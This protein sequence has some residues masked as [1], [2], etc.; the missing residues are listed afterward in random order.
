MADKYEDLHEQL[1]GDETFDL[2]EEEALGAKIAFQWLDGHRDQT[3]GRT[4]T[5][6]E[7]GRWSHLINGRYIETPSIIDFLEALGITVVPDSK[8]TNAD[9][10]E[11][12][13][14]DYALQHG[15]MRGGVDEIAAHL[16]KAG[17]KASGGDNGE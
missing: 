1:V 13:L 2:T 6:G 3:P 4:I 14:A 10:L 17:V 12:A 15:G 5:A 8:P 16:D 7:V 9:R 11:K